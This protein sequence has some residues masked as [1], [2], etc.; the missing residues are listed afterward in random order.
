LTQGYW[1]SY[2]DKI[3][4]KTKPTRTPFATRA[5]NAET[6]MPLSLRLRKRQP[7]SLLIGDTHAG[8]DMRLRFG[9]AFTPHGKANWAG[10]M[11]QGERLAHVYARRVR[12]FASKPAG[13][14]LC[15]DVG[16]TPRASGHAFVSMTPSSAFC[17]RFEG[18]NRRQVGV[19]VL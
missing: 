15:Q 9:R 5:V 14:I 11:A 16:M 6:L 1:A 2:A 13:K 12:R 10:W 4:A 18:L 7:P 3:V 8:G 17:R 19:S